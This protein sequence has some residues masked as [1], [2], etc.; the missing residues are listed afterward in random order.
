MSGLSFGERLRNQA[1]Y[2]TD[3]ERVADRAREV[4]KTEQ[5]GNLADR[6]SAHIRLEKQITDLDRFRHYDL[7]LEEN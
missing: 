4:V 3:L 5:Q 2:V 6:Y 1:N 7:G